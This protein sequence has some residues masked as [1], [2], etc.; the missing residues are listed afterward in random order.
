MDHVLTV[1]AKW[2]DVPVLTNNIQTE[3]MLDRME[4]V[5]TLKFA[6]IQPTDEECKSKFIKV[7]ESQLLIA[8]RWCG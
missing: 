1:V 4:V 2:F 3:I 8:G 5:W 6:S 7:V